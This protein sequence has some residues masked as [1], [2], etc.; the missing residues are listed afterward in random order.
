M[1][2]VCTEQDRGVIMNLIRKKSAE[3]LFMISDIEAYGF[4]SVIQKVWGQFEEGKLVAVM[5]RFNSNHIIYSEGN[6]DAKGFAKI[7]LTYPGPFEVSGLQHVVKLV[8]PFIPYPTLRDVETYYA[9][10][11]SLAYEVED[12]YPDVQKLQPSEYEENIEL[13]KSIPEFVNGSFS[14]ESRVRAEQDQTG[15]T[16]VMRD[17]VGVMVLSATSTAENKDAA[18]IVGV[19]TRPGYERK[20]YAT[21]ILEKLCTDLLNE[22]KTLC[23]FYSNPKAG[24]IYK[25]LGFEDIGIW[26][27]IR[28]YKS[29]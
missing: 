2:R 28:Y 20:G 21:R 6:F 14:V 4:D 9:K 29:E 12:D 16:Y 18:M 10:C 7:I 17:E 23:L 27:L 1:I 3:N 19:G 15:R 24:A 26:T 13:L 25:R 22:G 8:R 11:T 5:L